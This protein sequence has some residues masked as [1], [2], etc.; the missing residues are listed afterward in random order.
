MAETV[1][2][3]SDPDRFEI[4]VDE[5]VAGSALFVDRDDRRIFF[6]TE[7]GEEFGGRGLGGTL[8]RQALDATHADGLTIVP[9]CPYVKHF[10]D[11]HDDWAD[12]VS[13]PTPDDLHVVPR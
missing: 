9:V 1:T 5:G 7:V 2:R 13:R 11:K 12:S 6:H 4:S 3:Q 8:V 10:L